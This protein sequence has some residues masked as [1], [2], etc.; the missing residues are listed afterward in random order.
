M[1][2]GL[3]RSGTIRMSHTEP[4]KEKITI[5]TSPPKKKKILARRQTE[6]LIPQKANSLMAP[7]PPPKPRPK[8]PT[9]FIKSQ[10]VS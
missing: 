9:F 10:P 2:K 4:S 6:S 5:A 1:A 8:Q 7:T 3:K